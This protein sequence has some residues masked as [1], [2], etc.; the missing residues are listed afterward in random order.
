[1]VTSIVPQAAVTRL[2]LA[3]AAVTLVFALGACGTQ[4]NATAGPAESEVTI[5][6]K[7]NVFDPGTVTVPAGTAVKVTFVNQGQNVH[8]VEI[9]GLV[10]E[11]KLQPGQNRS[12]TITP[13]QQ[14]YKMYCEIHEDQGMVGQFVGQ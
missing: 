14:T 11:T 2:L 6:V 1:M 10:A 4:E 9:K 13:T 7:D 5:N 12:F 3:L 8:E